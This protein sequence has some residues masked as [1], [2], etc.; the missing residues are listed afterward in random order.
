MDIFI[1][2][3]HLIWLDTF[4]LRIMEEFLHLHLASSVGIKKLNAYLI[5]ILFAVFFP[6]LKIL[7]LLSLLLQLSQRILW[8]D[9][10]LLCWALVK[11]G[12]DRS[13]KV[14]WFYYNLTF[15]LGSFS[16]T[17]S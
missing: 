6:F 2:S 14:F 10:Y 3:S 11:H 12:S 7:D 16:V 13:V 1:L 15:S 8:S 17:N 5:S 9:L 4:P